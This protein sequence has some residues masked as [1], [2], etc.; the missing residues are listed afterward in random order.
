MSSWCC[1]YVITIRGHGPWKC[2]VR[3]LT[4]CTDLNSVKYELTL[5]MCITDLNNLPY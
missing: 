3:T 2:L 1:G 5:V 4:A